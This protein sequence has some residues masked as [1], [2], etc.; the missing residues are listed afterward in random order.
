MQ[1]A[2][3]RLEDVQFDSDG[4]L[5]W[6]ESLSGVTALMRQNGPDAPRDIS[7]GLKISA[8]VG[9]GGGDFT[10]RNGL[11]IFASGGRLY[12]ADTQAGLPS[13]ITPQ[14]GD[15]ASPSI[16]PDGSQVL[17]MRATWGVLSARRPI[18]RPES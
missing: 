18:M 10:V 8:G 12:R 7:G 1:G 13:P 11:A 5:T 16:S 14:F 9:Y 17:F 4:S 3:L 6:L 15:C 2:R